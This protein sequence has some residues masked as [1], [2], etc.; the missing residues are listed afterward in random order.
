MNVD[1]VKEA[2][3]VKI[4]G[5]VESNSRLVQV[6]AAAERGDHTKARVLALGLVRGEGTIEAANRLREL[7]A[8]SA[9]FWVVYSTPRST[10]HEK[11]G[12]HCVYSWPGWLMV[13]CEIN[14]LTEWA[15]L[16][17]EIDAKNGS[18]GLAGQTRALAERLMEEE[19]RDER[20]HRP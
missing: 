5:Y 3:V 10:K 7:G 15:E 12:V 4:T 13:G 1:P 17:D 18:E 2:M 19:M 14:T 11:I 8:H 16:A 6:V 9:A 20:Q